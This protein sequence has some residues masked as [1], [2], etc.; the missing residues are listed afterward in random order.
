MNKYQKTMMSFALC[1]CSNLYSA[2]EE[3]E[4]SHMPD[5]VVCGYEGSHMIDGR[6][7]SNKEV[8]VLSKRRSK[9]LTKLT[10]CVSKVIEK[11]Y[12]GMNSVFRGAIMLNAMKTAYDS[13]SPLNTFEEQ[14]STCAAT[15]RELKQVKKNGYPT[16]ASHVEI[17]KSTTQ[18]L[19]AQLAA[20]QI[21]PLV[22]ELVLQALNPQATCHVTGN[23]KVAGA[24]VFGASFGA[25]GLKCH[26]PLGRRFK[27]RG[28]SA[29]ASLGLGAMI[30]WKEGK[31]TSFSF[32]LQ[33]S[34]L[35][36]LTFA[37]TTV[38]FLQGEV[39]GVAN[40]TNTRQ[41]DAPGQYSGNGFGFYGAS[42]VNKALLTR[43]E[44]KPIFDGL[45]GAIGIDQSTFAREI[46][47]T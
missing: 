5:E 27:M 7:L 26:T 18:V 47:L 31:A 44:L 30:A 45:W 2:Q 1:L 3:I 29:G 35:S 20:R 12:G 33:S 4:F 39:W 22:Q 8:K 17:S 34:R 11:Q 37:E 40:A 9:I 38:A 23:I 19:L 13:R 10:D 42:E 6:V 41:S 28:I 16:T 32:P 36:H 24:M 25:I 15:L 21:H 46:P 43:T 14:L